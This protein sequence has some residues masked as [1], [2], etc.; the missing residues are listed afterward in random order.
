MIRNPFSDDEYI[1]EG[2]VCQEYKKAAGV[3]KAVPGPGWLKYKQGNLLFA[4]LSPN[5]RQSA[6]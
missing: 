3:I 5:R 2:I 1:E 4:A 6:A